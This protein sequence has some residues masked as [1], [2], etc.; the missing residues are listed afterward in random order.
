ME[1]L[2]NNRLNDREYEILTQ[3][4]DY[5]TAGG[6]SNVAP[7]NYYWALNP[8]KMARFL[9]KNLREKVIMQVNHNS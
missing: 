8:E 5:V 6:G 4:S 7:S 2:N 9:A 1:I 3:I